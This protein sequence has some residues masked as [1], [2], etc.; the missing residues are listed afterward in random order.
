MK[1]E[2]AF[3]GRKNSSILGY[4]RD[5]L[6]VHCFSNT[7]L[8][9]LQRNLIIWDLSQQRLA[10]KYI[11]CHHTSDQSAIFGQP[12]LLCLKKFYINRI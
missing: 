6:C 5:K 2:M 12:L 10:S 8:E 1:R 4:F 11:V 7:S 9:I 3:K